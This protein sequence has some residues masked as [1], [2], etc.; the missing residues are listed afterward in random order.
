MDGFTSASIAMS[1]TGP[2]QD[3]DQPLLESNRA[4]REETEVS[5]APGGLT[6]WAVPTDAI[7]P[8]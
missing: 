1:V 7:R 4:L 5:D 6:L 3:G 8:C 2:P